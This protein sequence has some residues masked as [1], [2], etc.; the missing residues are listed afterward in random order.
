MKHNVTAI[1]F[2]KKGRVLS[3]GRNNYTKT[4]PLQAFYASKVNEPSKQFLHAEIDAIIRCNHL[5]LA[6][7]IHVYR[8]GKRGE[9]RIAKPCS[10]CMSAIEKTNIKHILFTENER[11][12]K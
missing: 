11:E 8:F 7:S 12:K 3:I 10:V 5:D 2:S 1:I 6:H 4:H 9:K